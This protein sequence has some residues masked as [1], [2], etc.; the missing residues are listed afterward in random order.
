[1]DAYINI[2][3]SGATPGCT[4]DVNSGHTCQG[5]RDVTLETCDVS[6]STIGIDQWG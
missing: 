5:A 1:M 3:V 2:E 4:D 6:V